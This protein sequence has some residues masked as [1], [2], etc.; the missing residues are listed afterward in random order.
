MTATRVDGNPLI[1]T[2]SGAASGTWN[3]RSGALYLTTTGD[4]SFTVNRPGLLTVS[5][6][7][8]GGGGKVEGFGGGGGAYA[9]ATSIPVAPGVTYTGKVGAAGLAR[10]DGG[11]YSAGDGGT[12]EFRISAGTIYL[13]LTGGHGN[14]DG[15]GDVNAAG[16]VVNYGTG[17]SGGAGGKSGAAGSAGT[18]GGGGG[19]YNSSAGGAGG[20]T[21]SGTS[22]SNAAA[23]GDGGGNSD[24]GYGGGG[25]TFNGSHYGGGGGGGGIPHSSGNPASANGAQGALKFLLG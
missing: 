4:Y 25:Y 7:S 2:Y 20:S 8:G 6:V 24:G 18:G 11:S 17:G 16:G 10:I 23:A 12:T 21:G 14:T 13:Q 1:V 5:G 15:D 22:G 9:I 19:S 3:S